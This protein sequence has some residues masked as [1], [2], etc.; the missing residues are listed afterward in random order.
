MADENTSCLQG[1]KSTKKFLSSLGRFGNTPFLHTMYGS[2]ELPQAFCRLC[3]VF[4]GTYYLGKDVNGIILCDDKVKGIITNGQ[5]ISCK[6]FVIGVSNCPSKIK[7]ASNIKFNET[8][9]NRK[10]CLLSDSILPHET[11]KEQLT[12]ASIKIKGSTSPEETDSSKSV[13]TFVQE[14]GFGPS[15]CPKGMYVLH[16]TSKKCNDIPAFAAGDVN[17]LLT[18]S[19]TLLWSLDFNIIS[20]QTEFEKDKCISNVYFC[21]GPYYEL[22]YD[23]TI[24]HAEKICKLINT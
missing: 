19:E 22:D 2:G 4:G 21:N 23:S 17:S 5:R 1:L 10:I 24:E 7:Q 16:M 18:D 13:H 15:V 3:A 12:F 9:L 6:N 20:R 11:G 8:I 14:A